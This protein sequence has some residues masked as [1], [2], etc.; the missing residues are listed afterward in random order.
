MTRRVA[1]FRAEMGEDWWQANV[2]DDWNLGGVS[3]ETPAERKRLKALAD[4]E[5]ASLDNRGNVR[6]KKESAA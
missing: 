3:D 4:A 1:R 6:A 5:W 2:T